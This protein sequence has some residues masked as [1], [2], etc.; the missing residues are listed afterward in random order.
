[1]DCIAGG[2]MPR[3]E[4]L[5]VDLDLMDVHPSVERFGTR[6]FLACARDAR[7]GQDAGAVLVPVQVNVRDVATHISYQ[8][9]DVWR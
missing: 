5:I 7:L 8:N 3:W 2:P 4:L 1:M 9:G 6:A